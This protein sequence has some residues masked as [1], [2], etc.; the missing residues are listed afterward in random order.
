TPG[1]DSAL[2][3]VAVTAGG[4]AYAVRNP[5]EWSYAAGRVRW[6]PASFRQATVACAEAARAAGV[7]PR[8]ENDLYLGPGTLAAWLIRDSAAVRR[9]RPPVVTRVGGTFNRWRVEVWMGERGGA[10]GYRCL[11]TPRT[12]RRGPLAEFAR[13]DSITEMEPGALP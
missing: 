3:A 5:H 9:L 12:G 8:E 7:R 6:S 2:H 1:A 4:E 11:F 13:T 10:S